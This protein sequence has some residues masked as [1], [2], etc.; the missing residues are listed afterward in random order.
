MKI[1]ELSAAETVKL[2]KKRQ[3][4]AKEVLEAYLNEIDRKEKMLH[5]YITL[6]V[7]SAY[8]QAESLQKKIDAKEPAGALA[9]VPAGVKDN[10]CLQGMRT[11]CASKMLESFMPP[12]TATAVKKL[13]DAGAVILGKTNM[14]EFSMGNTTE[15]SYFGPTKNP[16]HPGHVP[17][18]SSG[19][20]AAC[21][22]AKEACIALGTDTGGSIRQPASYCGVVGIKPTYG[23]VSRYGLIA[24]ASSMDQVGSI[25]SNVTDAALL[26]EVI[27]G[28]DAK[29]ATSR[30]GVSCDYCTELGKSIRGIRIGIPADY[31]GEGLHAEVRKKVLEAGRR[32]ESLGAAVEEFN[33]GLLKYAP[34]AYYVIAGAE[35]SSN[36]ARYDGVKYGYRAVRYDSLAQMYENS[37]REGFGAEVCRRIEMGKFSLSHG[38]YEDYYLQALKIRRLMKQSF[39]SAFG[40]YDVILGPVAPTAAPEFGSISK[41]LIESYWNDIYTVAANLAGLPA[42]SLPFG[43]DHQG[44]PIGVQLLG[45]C[46]EEKKMLRCAY[47]LEQTGKGAEGHEQCI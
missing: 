4:S 34:P 5:C 19:G 35:A 8:A 37:R 25:A 47:A 14:D 13:M 28:H 44:L 46:C 10:L 6:D 39:D 32:L 41:N 30:K 1:V 7:E 15:T 27:S 33:L 3:L 20:S 17:G 31:L 23:A 43:K 11:T 18:G 21:V 42:M 40:K 38:F 12:Y 26:L 36:L 9:G 2:V 24:Y 29:D 45:N 22:A 16:H